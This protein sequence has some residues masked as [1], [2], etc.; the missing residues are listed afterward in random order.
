MNE[1][2]NNNIREYINNMFNNY[3]SLLINDMTRKTIYD[4]IES[5]TIDFSKVYNKY[6]SLKE[7][8]ISDEEVKG[9]FNL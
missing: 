2:N 8:N 3:S 1:L 6:K 9:Y 5:K 4:D 7:D